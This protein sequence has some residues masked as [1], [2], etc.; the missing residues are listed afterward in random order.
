LTN[1]RKKLMSDTQTTFV[2]SSIVVDA[3]IERA[4]AVF[5]EDIGS[6]WPPE[7]HILEAQLAGMVFEPREGGHVYDLGVDGSECRWARVLAYQP[8]DRVVISW[9]VSLKWQLETNP[10]RTSEVEVRFFSEARDR[11]RVELEHRN[12]DRHGEG[13]EGMR[14]AVGSPEGWEAGLQSFGARFGAA[15]GA[16][17]GAPC[18]LKGFVFRLVPPRPDFAFTLTDDERATMTDHLGYWSRLTER[19]NVVAF[20]PVADPQGSYGIGIVLAEDIAAAEQFRDGDPAM[21]SPHGFRTEIAPMLQLVTPDGH[22]EG[23]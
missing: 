13:W 5:T 21:K 4:F 15:A 7:H 14:N 16:A 9:D 20:G 22:F 10:D 1:E 19:G 8:P 18:Q 3:P 12:I 23:R 17:A 6:W 2:R 11:T